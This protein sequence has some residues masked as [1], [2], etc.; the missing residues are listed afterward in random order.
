M[1]KNLKANFVANNSTLCLKPFKFLQKLDILTFADVL[2]ALISFVIDVMF[3][4]PVSLLLSCITC[5]LS[6]LDKIL[7]AARP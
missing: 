4:N 7:L 5:E 6:R 1:W 2:R 3:H